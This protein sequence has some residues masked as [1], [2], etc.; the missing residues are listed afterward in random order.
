MCSRL[1][2]HV[3]EP[4]ALHGGEELDPLSRGKVQNAIVRIAD[5]A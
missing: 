4:A 5:I 1:V 3:V 2:G